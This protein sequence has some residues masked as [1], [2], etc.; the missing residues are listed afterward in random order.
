MRGASKIKALVLT[1]IMGLVV[2]LGVLG[3]DTI[4]TYMS[5]AT[6]DFEPSEVGQTVEPNGNSAVVSWKTLKDS[7]GYVEYGTTPASLLLRSEIDS[8]EVK[9]SHSVSL[10][11][12]KANMNYY[13]R[14]R[15]GVDEAKKSEWEVFDNAGIPYSFNTKVLGGAP[16]N[17]TSEPNNVA[18]PT[19]TISLTPT[20]V[21]TPGVAGDCSDNK[22]DF[23]GDGVVNSI[24]FI[25]CRNK[26]VGSPTV[27]PSP[28]GGAKCKPGVDYDGDGD[29]NSLDMIKC[30]QSN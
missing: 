13:F 7:K 23:N 30:L 12:L 18:S 25:L 22:T 1:L 16:Q 26:S 29:I 8:A 3:I 19:A 14:L 21:T 4:K 11:P 9:T 20:A 6:S 5:G 27:A 24:D 2:V 15:I 28:T 10:S 17:R